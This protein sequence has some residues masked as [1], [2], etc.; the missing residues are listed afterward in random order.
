MLKY[1]LFLDD[2]RTLKMAYAANSG[3]QVH[4][5]KYPIVIAKNAAEF[6]KIITERGLPEMVSF[7]HDLGDFYYE[8]GIKKERSG[9]T[10]AKWLGDYCMENHKK[11]PKFS[12]HS[13]N[14]VGKENIIKTFN[15]YA[16]HIEY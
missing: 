10:C 15:F 7:D 8:D 16:K 14:P 3:L 13:D 9:D 11:M 5:E 2:R 6:I 12:V 4:L 1:N